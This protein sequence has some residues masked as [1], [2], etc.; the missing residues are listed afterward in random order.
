[1]DRYVII[2][3]GGLESVVAAEAAE[4]LQLTCAPQALPR[5]TSDGHA[6]V[7]KL[8]VSTTSPP[9][10]LRKLRSA[11]S[12]LAFASHTSG[13]C[14]GTTGLT[15]A[16]REIELADW[17]GAL[18]CW[19]AHQLCEG[20]PAPERP[21]FRASAVRDGSHAF[22]SVELAGLLGER[23]GKRFGLPVRLTDFDLE[24]VAILHDGEL[25]TGVALRGACARG[26]RGASVPRD[27]RPLLP[28]TGRMVTLRP[29]VAW[30]LATL[31]R[32]TPGDVVIDAMG[33]VGTIPIEVRTWALSLS[34]GL[35]P[36]AVSRT[37]TRPRTA[38]AR[39]WM[40]GGRA[41]LFA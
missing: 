30:T 38:A 25:T 35:S 3:L 2:C 15:D 5:G 23:F 34:V 26:W 39:V 1:M 10:A 9:D 6:G 18:R 29:S 16:E 36:R 32:L 41:S 20:R 37:A 12:L 31:A 28:W 7:G 21:T 13:A 4:H 17:T 8:L 11:Q 27:A 14:G 19:R 40:S 24:V 22:G 33:G